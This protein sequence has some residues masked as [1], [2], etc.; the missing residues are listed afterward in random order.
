MT[1]ATKKAV[2]ATPKPKEP[3][4]LEP[5]QIRIHDNN[6]PIKMDY[7]FQNVVAS[8]KMIEKSTDKKIET[9]D[10]TVGNVQINIG[11]KNV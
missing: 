7:F 9:F 6:I 3:E 5:I 10:L 2:K 4:P 8:I 1:E 11:F